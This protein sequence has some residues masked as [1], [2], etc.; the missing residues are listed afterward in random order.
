MPYWNNQS[1]DSIYNNNTNNG[2]ENFAIAFR[3]LWTTHASME[4]SEMWKFKLIE[5]S[6]HLFFHF[7]SF[8]A[9]SV[10]LSSII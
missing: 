7:F 5:Q 6:L 2:S 4:K 3:G 10:T 8:Q 9:S 1:I